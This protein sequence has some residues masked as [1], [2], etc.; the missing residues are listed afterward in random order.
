MVLAIMQ[1]TRAA[2]WDV[3]GT[4]VDTAELHYEAFRR[5]AAEEGRAFSRADFVWTF[6][7][8]NPE[9]MVELF[10]ERGAGEAGRAMAH[11]K[12]EYY[13][14]AAR[15]G[16]QLLPGAQSLIDQLAA[17]GWAQAIGSSA[18]P[19]NLE[20]ILAL[21]GVGP[22]M[23]AV[24]SGD[25]TERGKPDPEVFLTAARRCGVPPEQCVVFEDAVA[26]VQAARAAGMACVAVTF[27]AHST[28]AELTRAGAH[29]V[30]ASLAELSL[31]DLDALLARG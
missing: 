25:D 24:I 23:R 15:A 8:R 9:I 1:T 31:A 5:F 12:E 26:G 18:P 28:P 17:A 16:V 21:T 6:G 29:V 30:V 10:G 27:C 3:D 13:R 14:E 7:R 2:I 19:A 4:L 11:R 22:H 20:L